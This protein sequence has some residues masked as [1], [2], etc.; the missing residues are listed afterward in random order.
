MWQKLNKKLGGMIG[1]LTVLFIFVYLA[2]WVSNSLLG[3]H[4]VMKEL[5]DLWQLMIPK[6]VEYFVKSKW[7]TV[8][9]VD[10]HDNAKE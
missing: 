8:D 7:N 4:F 1:T 10:P 5:V 3:T 2:S 9:G 6:I